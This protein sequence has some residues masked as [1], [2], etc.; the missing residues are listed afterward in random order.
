MKWLLNTL[1]IEDRAILGDD[2]V[3]VAAQCSFNFYRRC[4]LFLPLKLRFR[5]HRLNHDVDVFS[6]VAVR[7]PL[8][9]VEF[10]ETNSHW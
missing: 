6:D 4:A 8:Q 5:A 1:K 7:S 9:V 2:H 3:C 10:A